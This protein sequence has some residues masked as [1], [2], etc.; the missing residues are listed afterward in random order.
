MGE[1]N[2]ISKGVSS[3]PGSNKYSKNKIIVSIWQ[4]TLNIGEK[5][6]S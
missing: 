1:E 5:I 3:D 6:R 4:P 2:T